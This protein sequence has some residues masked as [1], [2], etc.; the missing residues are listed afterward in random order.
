MHLKVFLKLKII[1]QTSY[2][3]LLIVNKYHTKSIYLI[4]LLMDILNLLRNTVALV[5]LPGR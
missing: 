5:R 1:I 2:K 4:L 3:K